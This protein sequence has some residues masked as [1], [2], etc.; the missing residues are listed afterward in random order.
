M[1]GQSVRRAHRGFA[2]GDSALRSHCGA[3]VVG[4]LPWVLGCLLG[5]RPVES[6]RGILCSC[7]GL[8]SFAATTVWKSSTTLHGGSPV[9]LFLFGSS[10]LAWGQG[11]AARVGQ[12]KGH[13][14]KHLFCKH[15]LGSPPDPNTKP[16]K[17]HHSGKISIYSMG[18]LEKISH[19]LL[20]QGLA[21]EQ[22]FRVPSL[23]TFLGW[24]SLGGGVLSSAL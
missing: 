23:L 6:R 12:T 13:G 24:V 4:C 16:E 9:F 17:S 15:I 22:T 1:S 21:L 10:G 5:R 2:R 11:F 19:L 8:C 14:A 20:L 18:A 7:K 3:V